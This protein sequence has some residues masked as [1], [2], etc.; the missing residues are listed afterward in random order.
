MAQRWK[1][2]QL[3]IRV[4]TAEKKVIQKAAT[5]AGMGMSEYILSRLLPQQKQKLQECLRQLRSAR[6]I[7]FGLAEVHDLFQK[8]TSF[9]FEDS[10]RENPLSRLSPYLQNYIAAMVEETALQKGVS[11]P[12]WTK[13]I[14]PLAQPVFGSAL[15][16]L[17]LHLLTQS[18]IPFRKRNIFIDST[19]GSRV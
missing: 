13:D 9:E 19:I 15:K 5:T 1:T 11:V 18:P 7:S 3:Q 17:R 12:M 8:M 16:N 2:A 4:S 14:A 10:L 6:E